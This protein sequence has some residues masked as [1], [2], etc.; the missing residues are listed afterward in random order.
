MSAS[1]QRRSYRHADQKRKARVAFANN[2][3]KRNPCTSL[4]AL[5]HATMQMTKDQSAFMMHNSNLNDHSKI[6]SADEDAQNNSFTSRTVRDQTRFYFTFVAS[7][8]LAGES[9]TAI[10]CRVNRSVRTVIYFTFYHNC[11][12]IKVLKS[13]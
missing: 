9:K 1:Q 2:R 12:C 4:S 13:H 8:K 3:A 7:L 11:I 5:L 6:E 10:G